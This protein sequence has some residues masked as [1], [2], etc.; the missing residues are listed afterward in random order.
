MI[1]KLDFDENNSAWRAHQERSFKAVSL[2]E[3]IKVDIAII[4]GGMTGISTARNLIE[5]Y[6]DKKIA[7]LE[8]KSLANGA[9]GRNGGLVLNWFH[10]V[11]AEDLE[12]AQEIYGITQETMES[13][14][15]MA[16][17]A[18]KEDVFR[19]INCATLYTK[20]AHFTAAATEARKVQT[21]GIPLQVLSKSELQQHV[22]A[23]EVVGAVIDPSAG[24]LDG[25]GFIHAVA[26][27]LKNKGV[28]I[29]ENT[30]VTEIIENGTLVL[31][32][33]HHTVAADAMV[34]A[35]NAYSP[36]LGY[37]KD[38]LIPLHSYVIGTEPLSEE[39]WKELGFHSVQGFSDDRSRLAYGCINRHGELIF[40]GGS[41]AA[42][43]YCYGGKT[44]I[45]VKESKPFEA[46]R[47][48]LLKYF[49]Q[50]SSLELKYKWTG[51][52]GITL[53]RSCMMGVQG[54]HRNIFYAV[55]FSGHG[56]TMATLAGRVLTDMYSG[57]DERWKKMPFFM[58]RGH[59]IPPE[60]FRW[61]GYKAFTT[62]TGRSPRKAAH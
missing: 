37:F 53:D 5:R 62:C 54:S 24:Q 2:T 30:P 11:E 34:L 49:P 18:G 60:P 47:S 28:Q 25:V 23:D 50:L 44:G 6:P 40:G 45:H 56:L 26:A 17:E 58:K 19:T 33:E 22:R 48:V 61:I 21:V 8:A 59:T 36:V 39:Q 41:N 27:V 57:N 4:G 14:R 52:V 55:G 1:T 10:D 42:Y 13:M 16:A 38:K 43:R 20:E 15:K 46:V 12:L 7:L 31:H 9:S 3:D 32:T 35:S 29:Y 51:P